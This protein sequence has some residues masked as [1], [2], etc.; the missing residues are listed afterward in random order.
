MSGLRWRSYEKRE[1]TNIIGML[2]GYLNSVCIKDG[3]R[4]SDSAYG[5]CVCL[6]RQHS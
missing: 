5:I 3:N 4:L 2:H 6:W 1:R